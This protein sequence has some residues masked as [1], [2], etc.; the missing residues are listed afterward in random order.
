MERQK[1]YTISK[2]SRRKG[3]V[4]TKEIHYDY[5]LYMILVWDIPTVSKKI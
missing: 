4:F 5:M 1:M 3:K 2:F